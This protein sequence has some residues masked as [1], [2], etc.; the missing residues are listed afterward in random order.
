MATDV[1]YHERSAPRYA[2]GSET[3]VWPEQV[4]DS[5]QLDVSTAK[6]S[7]AFADGCIA[8]VV[9]DVD[10][11]AASLGAAVTITTANSRLLKANTENSIYIKPGNRLG[12]LAA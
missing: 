11:R 8:R 12:L 10:C 5:V 4:G 7:S 2:F 9:P 3:G 6:Y 1:S